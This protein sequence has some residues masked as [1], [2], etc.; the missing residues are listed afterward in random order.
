MLILTSESEELIVGAALYDFTVL[1]HTDQIGVSDSRQPVCYDDCG[2]I[3][4][5]TFESLLHQS[6]ALG[7]KG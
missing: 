6:F 7:I 3:L 1:H 4:H 5:E 2:S